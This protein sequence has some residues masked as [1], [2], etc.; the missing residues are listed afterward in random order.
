MS[1]FSF[2]KKLGARKRGVHP[3][4]ENCLEA[5]GTVCEIW[6]AAHGH[7][8]ELRLLEQSD[9]NL[10]STLRGAFIE[11]PVEIDDLSL[12]QPLKELFSHL[13]Q[14]P[15]DKTSRKFLGRYGYLK[16]SN[17]ARSISSEFNRS[18]V[19][20]KDCVVNDFLTMMG[21]RFPIHIRDWDID[22]AEKPPE[23]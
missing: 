20:L 10:N 23:A 15:Y 18:E 2:F 19:V 6:F 7:E 16:L 17:G 22:G 3:E 11:P 9:G 5:G 4:V 13:E 1:F 14:C 8:F 21:K 12:E